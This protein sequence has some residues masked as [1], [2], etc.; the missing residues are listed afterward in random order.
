[1]FK[2]I[3]LKIAKKYRKINKKCARQKICRKKLPLRENL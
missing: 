1:M 3:C 2:N